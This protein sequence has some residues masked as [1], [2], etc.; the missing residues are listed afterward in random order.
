MQVLILGIGLQGRA[1]LYHLANSPDVEGIIAADSDLERA[2]PCA[3]K[4]GGGKTSCVK[5]A[6]EDHDAVLELMA[7]EVDVV[8]E[9]LPSYFGE[10]M[11]EL[12]IEAGVHLVNSSYA[13]EEILKLN[14]EAARKGVAILPEFGMDPGID[15]VMGAKARALCVLEET[16]GP[17]LSGR[18]AYN[19]G[20]GRGAPTGVSAQPVGAAVAVRL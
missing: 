17:W 5:L 19:A 15:L 13:S 3:K 7:S 4:F 20:V 2:A 1:A 11:G 6:T 9:L 14:A 8:I 12:A 16:G 18:R 10:V